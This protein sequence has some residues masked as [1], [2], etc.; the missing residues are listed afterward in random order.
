VQGVAFRASAYDVAHRQGLV[1]WVRNTSAGAVEGV[2]EG[3]ASEVDAFL[4]WVAHGP[5]GARV[6]DLQLKDLE[7][8]DDLERFEIR[9][10]V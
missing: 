8:A 5:P 3:E 10:T 1:G 7:V 2:I 9:R 6:D 4:A